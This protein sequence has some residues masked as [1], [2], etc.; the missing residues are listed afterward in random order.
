M[1]SNRFCISDKCSIRQLLFRSKYD[2]IMIV[3]KRDSYNTKASLTSIF[4]LFLI[5]QLNDFLRL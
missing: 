3:V 2:R 1:E 4:D 5:K